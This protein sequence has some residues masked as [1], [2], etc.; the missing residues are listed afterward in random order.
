MDPEKDHI[1]LMKVINVTKN[2]S[3]I[4]IDIKEIFS[5]IYIL[6]CSVWLFNPSVAWVIE[7]VN[8]LLSFSLFLSQVLPEPP[9]YGPPQTHTN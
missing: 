9:V 8:I 4:L 1:G 3:G 5:I 6:E 2:V 7:T